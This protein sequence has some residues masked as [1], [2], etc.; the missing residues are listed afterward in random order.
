M[1]EGTLSGFVRKINKNGLN[2]TKMNSNTNVKNQHPYRRNMPKIRWHRNTGR[3]KN[4]SGAAEGKTRWTYTEGGKLI[5]HPSV[6]P[7]KHWVFQKMETLTEKAS[8]GSFC[9]DKNHF[10]PNNSAVIDAEEIGWN[11]LEKLNFFL[12]S[13][14]LLPAHFWVLSSDSELY[15]IFSRVFNSKI[16]LSLSLSKK[17]LFRNHSRHLEF[18]I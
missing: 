1:R 15:Y 17:L 10:A 8:D 6:K 14:S 13:L 16:F 5:H 3:D 12:L 4:A 11:P 2:G 9:I 18:R 7:M